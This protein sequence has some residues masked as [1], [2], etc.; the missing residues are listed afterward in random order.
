MQLLRIAFLDSWLQ[1]AAEGSGTAVGIGG[2]LEA[3]EAQGH[4][5]DRI[6]PPPDNRSITARRLLY[7]LR[8]ARRFDPSPY[9]LI[10]GFD[11]DGVWRGAGDWRLGTRSRKKPESPSLQPLATGPYVCS[12]KGVIAEELQHERGRIR[13]LFS[14]LARLEGA[15]ARR[16]DRVI[17]TSEYCADRIAFHYNVPRPNIAIVPEGIDVRAWTAALAEAEPRSDQRPTILCVARQYPRKHVADLLRAFARLRR[18]LPDARL[19]LVGDGPEHA[20]LRSLAAELGIA[21]ATTFLGSIA[22][23][24]VKREYAHCDVFCLPSVQE[25]FGIVF[26][27]AMTAGKPIVAT[28]AAAMPEVV[29][30][31]ETGVLVPPGDVQ[32]LAGALLLLLTDHDRRR[33][34]GNAA[35]DRVTRYDWARVADRFLE[36]V[37]PLLRLEDRNG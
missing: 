23:H 14:L 19:R 35:R 5:V 37:N 13:L 26:L 15:N 10:V 6:A 9:D 3:L 33:Q 29:C 12:I 27:E 17:T 7:N 34:Y 20:A 25:G 4:Q 11:I 8:L 22:D 18:W 31:G 32:S 30:H 2:L 21:D 36:V 16:A 1:S 28:T 24:E